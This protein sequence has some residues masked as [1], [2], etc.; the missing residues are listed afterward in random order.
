M[1]H[2]TLSEAALVVLPTYNEAENVEH[3]IEL[4]LQQAARLHVVVVDDSS[5]DGTGEIADRL[6]ARDPRVAVIHRSGKL[7]LGTAYMAGFQRA[8]SL[9]Y[10]YAITMDADF[11]HHPRYLP[12]LLALMPECDLAIG[13]RYVPGGGTEGWPLRRRILSSG[14][15]L[16]ARTLLGLHAHDCTAGFRCY[17]REVLE[18]IELDT[19]FSS[20]YSFLVEMLTRCERRGFR[21]RELPIVFR[22]REAGVSKISRAEVYRSVYTVFR[23]RFS[24]LPWDRWEARRNR[25]A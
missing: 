24:F 21:V 2:Q 9:G 15:N 5:P 3:L 16:F 10:G 14:A 11:S 8:L 18:S 23:L 4:I 20:G 19:I 22:D 25:A 1:P 12:D 17:R 7:G 13:S 6:C